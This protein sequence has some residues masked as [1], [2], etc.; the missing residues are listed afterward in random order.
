MKLINSYILIEKD[1]NQKEISNKL[2]ITIKSNLKVYIDEKFDCITEN[3][4]LKNNNFKSINK[5]CFVLNDQKCF[6]EMSIIKIGKSSYVDFTTEC[7]KEKG[8]EILEYINDYIDSNINIKKNYYT[9][10]TYDSVSEFYCNKIYSKLNRFERLFRKLLFSIYI[11][12]FEDDYFEKA[13]SKDINNKV[14]GTINKPKNNFIS[15]QEYRNQQFFYATDMSDNIKILFEKS[16]TDLDEKE[17]VKFVEK[18]SKQEKD[19]KQIKEYILNLKPK[20]DWERF[21]SNKHF[22]ENFEHI[23]D[24]IR[25]DRNIVAHCKIFTK[26]KLEE[27]NNNLDFAIRETKKALV[28]T[29]KVDFNDK[30][31]QLDIERI[32]KIQNIISSFVSINQEMINAINSSLYPNQQLIETMKNITNPFFQNEQLIETM[33]NITNPFYK[34]QQLVE[35]M[36]KITNSLYP[37]KQINLAQKGINDSSDDCNKKEN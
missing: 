19:T 18:I 21:F 12:N 23:L 3:I 4:D 16:W 5:Y 15:K 6:F 35:T 20:S 30:R 31:K 24:L 13:I 8:I 26:Q 34:N 9:I 1:Q 10:C 33:K 28:I 17:K 25:I 22:D 32:E 14:K 27:F 7:T 29:E 36:E 37:A 2:S 11:I